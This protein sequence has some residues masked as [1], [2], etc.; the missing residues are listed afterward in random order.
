VRYLICDRDPLFTA[1]FRE[2]LET[3]G[4]KMVRIPPRSPNLNPFAERFVGSVRREC[5]DRVIPLGERHLRHLLH[6]YVTHYHEERN[7]QAL[8]N[9]L[10]EPTVAANDTGPIECRQRLGGL[11]RFYHRDAA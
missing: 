2:L 4:T 9:R 3:A 5:L 11:L 1:G 6:E 10:I 7:P 8:G